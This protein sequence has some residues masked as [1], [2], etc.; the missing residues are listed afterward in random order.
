MRVFKAKNP[1]HSVA[2]VAQNK[3]S[4]KQMIAWVKEK[5]PFKFET[6][7]FVKEINFMD[8]STCDYMLTEPKIHWLYD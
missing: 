1:L 3:R 4:A 8:V 6:L 2:I 7:L 5:Y